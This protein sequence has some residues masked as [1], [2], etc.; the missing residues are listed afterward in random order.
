MSVE[1]GQAARKVFSEGAAEA[2]RLRHPR[3]GAHHMLLAVLGLSDGGA[4]SVLDAFRVDRAAA[5][6]WIEHTF[7]VGDAPPDRGEMPYDASGMEVLQSAIGRARDAAAD[8]VTT[9]HVLLGLLHTEEAPGY[10]ALEAAGVD[11]PALIAA[12]TDDPS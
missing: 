1:F 12:L 5:R 3:F 10:R 6:T 8:R 2:N 4:S 9:A 7:P 11:V